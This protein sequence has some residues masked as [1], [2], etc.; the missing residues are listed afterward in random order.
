MEL[1]Q[2]DRDQKFAELHD[3][4]HGTTRTEVRS[5]Q[6]DSHLGHVYNVGPTDLGGLRY[7][8]NSTSLRF[9]RRDELEAEGYDEYWNQ[10]EDVESQNVSFRRRL[11]LGRAGLDS[12][13]TE[14]RN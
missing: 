12:R 6:G 11:L 9:V 4:A 10:V 5:R 1:Y 7:C 3:D 13:S 14:N 2:D 8:M